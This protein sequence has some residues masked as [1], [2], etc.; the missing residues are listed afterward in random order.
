MATE[1]LKPLG[2]A[3]TA[4]R[5]ALHVLAEQLISP[6]RKPRKEIALTSTPGGFGTP[7]FEFEGE[8]WQIRIEAG[9]LVVLQGGEERREPI[10]TLAAGAELVGAAL[11]PD[12]PPTGTE[13]LAVDAAESAKLGAFYALADAVLAELVADWAADEPSDPK[14]WPEHFDL[15]IEAGSEEAGVR[16]N[17]GFSPG[18]GEHPDPYL[19]VGPWSAKPRGE[20]WNA[21]GFPGAEHRYEELAA[22]ENPRATAL[23]F[24]RT[25]KA[26]LHGPG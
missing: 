26:A 21:K 17:Y 6:A 4:T 10:T 9:E 8:R 24:C 13:P 19:Y 20:L 3:F 25:R 16:A 5:E 15:A 23:E 1:A 12:G 22:A 2:P 14:L 11:F 7:E 18:D